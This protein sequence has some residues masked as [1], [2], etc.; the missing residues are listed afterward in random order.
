M[1]VL[2]SARI[3]LR[4]LRVN[5]LRSAL[6]MLG[7]IIGVGAVIAMVSVGAGAQAR[8]AEQIQS[9]GSNLI[10][11]LS[12][13]V[14]SSG[15]RLGFGSQLTITED[16][17]AAIAREVPAVQAAAP[18]S[19]GTAQVVYGNPNWSTVVQG[20]T[21]DYF[22]ARDWAVLYQ[23][24]KRLSD[25]EGAPGDARKR[26][27]Q[28]ADS[29]DRLAKKNVEAIT[30]SLGKEKGDKVVEAPW[31]AMLPTFLRDFDGVPAREALAEAWK[32]R[33]EKHQT[34]AV[35]NLREYYRVRDKDTAKAFDAGVEAVRVGFLWYECADATFLDAL[36]KGKED[37]KKLKLTKAQVKA[38]DQAVVPFVA[39]R[40]SGVSAYQDLN[41]SLD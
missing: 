36:A 15:T 18:S 12:G 7:I 34:D 1:N 17:A 10:I 23:V 40:K 26:A 16:D 38:Y 19:R 39:A 9:L 32:D 20:V 35:K 25:L 41:K 4:A 8:V 3:A 13:S 2:Q 5:K 22:E 14:T 11:V 6:T 30:K 37:A 33:L 27:A 24:A 21:V 31:V 28:T 29:V